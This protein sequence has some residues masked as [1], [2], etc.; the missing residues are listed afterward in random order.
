MSKMIDIICAWCGQPGIAA[1]SNIEKGMGQYCGLKCGGEARRNP[2]GYLNTY[3]YRLIYRPGHPLGCRGRSRDRVYEHWH[4]MYNI[5]PE[6]TM[7]AKKNKWTIHHKD[8][9]RDN[10]DPTN[11]EWRAPGQH[12]RGWTIDAMIDAIERA[13]YT[14]HGGA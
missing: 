8:G 1:K 2:H 13:G 9:N 4:T 3:G 12:P 7:W 14:V 5:D 6:F 11:L 10:N